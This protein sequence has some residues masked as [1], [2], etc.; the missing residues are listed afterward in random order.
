M[1]YPIKV[2]HVTYS[3]KV[4][5]IETLAT[6][7]H[8]Y[9]N[10]SKIQFDFAVYCNPNVEEH[11][12]TRVLE[13]GGIIHKLS[14]KNNNKSVRNILVERTNF[15]KLLKKE[16]YDIVHIHGSSGMHLIE[17][18]F[19]KFNR[20]PH[21]IIHSHSSKLIKSTKF[22]YIKKLLHYSCKW[23]WPYIATEYISCSNEA[24]KW[25]FPSKINGK[26]NEM[27]NG[28]DANIYIFNREK[29][30]Q[31]RKD[32]GFSGKFVVGHIGRF[33]KIKNHTFL[34]DV[35]IEIYRTNPSAILVLIGQ[36]ELEDEIKQKVS[37][38]GLDKVVYFLGVRKDIPDL[39][40]VMDLI[41]FP[42]LFEGLPIVGIESQAAGLP[43]IAADT[44]T[45][46]VKI[47][48]NV[49]FMSLQEPPSEW[50]VEAIAHH[51]K[52]ERR[53]MSPVIKEKGF[54]IQKTASNLEDFYEN[55]IGDKN[56][57]F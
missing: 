43:V 52:I 17:A 48:N 20:I 18:L 26:I 9:V 56:E 25:L 6:N 51:K 36:G 30:E 37:S 15:L 24:G 53:D 13:Q 29:R 28:I 2:L 1:N 10:K 22:Y 54:D 14:E 34:I 42:S 4:S 7:L 44:I 41:I 46:E 11:Y 12:D 38:L 5:G 50:A 32:M 16:K 55:L 21:I 8:K 23:M 45:N 49:K 40:Q 39:L 31:I 27:K 47:S 33:S 3:L 19:A 35:F 57:V